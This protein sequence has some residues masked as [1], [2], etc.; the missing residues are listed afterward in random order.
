MAE[1]S[2]RLKRLSKMAVAAI[3]D[4]DHDALRA[5]L[6][7]EPRLA[8][9]GPSEFGGQSLAH[10]AVVHGEAACLSEI[11]KFGGV[12]E[13][14]PGGSSLAI[15][16]A[17]NGEAA[18]LRELVA[19]GADIDR[20]NGFSGHPAAAYALA[21]GRLECLSILVEGG[22]QLDFSRR[23]GALIGE[24][25]IDVALRNGH[26]E[27]VAYLRACLERHSISGSVQ[28][29]AAGKSHPRSL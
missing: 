25:P 21:S 28:A 14:L 8:G 6:G 22:C 16:A 5:I 2:K 7:K 19:A 10:M 13:Q 27:C 3:K 15:V 26:S 17:S 29:A 18:C 20:L 11:L 9:L 12:D 4:G 24:T 1:P 23:Q